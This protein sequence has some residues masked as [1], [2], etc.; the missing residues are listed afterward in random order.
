M[1]KFPFI[2][3]LVRRNGKMS[4]PIPQ[5]LV[6]DL[7]K[8]SKFKD[9]RVWTCACG[10]TLKIRATFDRGDGPSNFEGFHD[11]LSVEKYNLPKNRVGHS[12]VSN[13]KLNWN[14]KAEEVGWNTNP[15]QCPACKLGL[16]V[17]DYKEKRR[18][19]LIK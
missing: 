6:Q 2:G 3:R 4:A 15:I 13:G 18:A 8:S 7:A 14:G 9:F 1:A 5:H 17:Q 19:G 11:E 16:S 12:I 10:A